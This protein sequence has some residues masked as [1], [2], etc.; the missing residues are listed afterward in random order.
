LS[1]DK[2]TWLAFH[3]GPVWQG[4]Y[5][6][7]AEFKFDVYGRGG[8][9]GW[10]TYQVWDN[11]EDKPQDAENHRVNVTAS[12]DFG[13]KVKVKIAGHVTEYNIRYAFQKELLN[14][15]SNHDKY[16]DASISEKVDD[17]TDHEMSR[18]P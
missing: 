11:D 3:D 17:V 12:G 16:A 13:V 4:D 1:W 14:S 6:E 5:V 18:R 15:S 2:K 8:M 9:A 7:G 10:Y